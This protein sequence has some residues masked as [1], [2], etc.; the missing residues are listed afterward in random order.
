[1]LEHCKLLTVEDVHKDEASIISV[2]SAIMDLK[3]PNDIKLLNYYRELPVNFGA[4]VVSIDRGVVEMKVHEMQ[5]ASML[6][7]KAT[8]IRSSH[9]PHGVIANVLRIRKHASMAY[10]SQ[11]SYVRI[12]A[13][14]RIYVR[15][16]VSGKIDAAFHND[17]HL[18]RGRIEDLSFSGV[19]IKT[20]EGS[21]LEEN[22]QGMVSIFLP[23]AKLEMPGKL[24]KKQGADVYVFELEVDSKSEKILSQFIFQQ[25][26]QII[27][28]LKEFC[29]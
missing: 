29:G 9:L 20:P 4:S 1:M 25:Q 21:I 11:F 8:F 23:D 19:A 5:I 18:V 6:Q 12:Y 10:L 13:D 2:L 22:I 17:Q 14:Q 24:L 26:S 16:K 27:R 28:E 3:L 7:Q 15:V